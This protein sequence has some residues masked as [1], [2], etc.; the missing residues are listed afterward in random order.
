MIPKIDFGFLICS[1]LPG[2]PV[3][4]A[5]YAS[6]LNSIFNNGNG[7]NNTISTTYLIIAPLMCGLFLDALRHM[8][9][10]IPITCMKNKFG[11]DDLPRDCMT[12]GT[13]LKYQ[14]AFF[15]NILATINTYFHIYEFFGN[16]LLSCLIALILLFWF[17][18]NIVP[19][20]YYLLGIFS[21]F[22]LMGMWIF[23][24]EQKKKISEWFS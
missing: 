4:I 19:P 6:V 5:L 23:S 16:F 9:S 14:D 22:S 2:V 17:G 12:E 11:W 1:Y 10:K 13:I 3:A 18:N 24:S 21:L 20:I 7:N 15:A 8:L